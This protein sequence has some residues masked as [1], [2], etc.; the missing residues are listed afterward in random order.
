MNRF[1]DQPVVCLTVDLFSVDIFTLNLITMGFTMGFINRTAVS[2]MDLT[3]MSLI[4]KFVFHF[5][6]VD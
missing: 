5:L 3:T 4:A 1:M 6:S 2:L